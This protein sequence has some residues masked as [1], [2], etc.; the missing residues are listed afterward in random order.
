MQTISEIKKAFKENRLLIRKKDRDEDK[1]QV[2][3][4]WF[5]PALWRP[6]RLPQ[7]ETLI[8]DTED[9]CL[10]FSVQLH[11]EYMK[12]HFGFGNFESEESFK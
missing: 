10:L 3:C 4:E 11:N 7:Y 5:K 6:E 8:F 12:K 9:N 1:S 2:D